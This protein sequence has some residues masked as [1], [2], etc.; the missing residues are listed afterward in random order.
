VHHR[1][2]PGGTDGRVAEKRLRKPR[3]NETKAQKAAYLQV[4]RYLL[5][6]FPVPAF[7]SHA[8]IALVD[9]DRIQ[10]YHANHSVILLSSVIN[11]SV[12]TVRAGGLDKFIAIVIAFSRLSLR[13]NGILH[14]LHGGKLFR[15]NQ[16]LPISNLV[17]GAVRMQEGNKLEF[18]GD[19][20]TGHSNTSLNPSSLKT[21]FSFLIQ[22]TRRSRVCLMM[23]SSSVENTSTRGARSGSLFRNGCTLSRR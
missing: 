16:N 20:K 5:E 8:T 10:F 22:P 14:N 1:S 18:G 11:F 19:E 17:R 15:D 13:D 23:S 7:R 2:T 4:G 21:S 12:T 9:R 3:T 6:Q